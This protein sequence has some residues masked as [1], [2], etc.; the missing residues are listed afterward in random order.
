M[1]HDVKVSDYVVIASGAVVLEHV[2]KGKSAY[3]G[4]NPTILPEVDI[5]EAA[6]VGASIV[7]R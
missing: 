6:L 1:V 4:A 2:T 5:G 7:V 3:I